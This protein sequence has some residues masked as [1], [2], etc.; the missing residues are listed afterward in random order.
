MEPDLAFVVEPEDETDEDEILY[1]ESAP[2][3]VSEL[4]SGEESEYEIDTEIQ[5]KTFAFCPNCGA[6]NEKKMDYCFNCNV[7]LIYYRQSKPSKPGLYGR[8]PV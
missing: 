5:K 6:E 3:E 1:P 4:D 7:R 2:H 8:E